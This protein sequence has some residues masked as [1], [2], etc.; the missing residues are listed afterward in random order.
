MAEG[1]SLHN[2]KGGAPGERVQQGA[3]GV[4][5][6]WNIEAARKY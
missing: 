5:V 4:V 3:A 1:T 2:I 6:I